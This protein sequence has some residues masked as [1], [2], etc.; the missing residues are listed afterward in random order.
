MQRFEV[1]HEGPAGVAGLKLSVGAAFRLKDGRS[2]VI[3]P[4]SIQ[5]GARGSLHVTCWRQV[6]KHSELQLSDCVAK[7]RDWH[8]WQGATQYE[9]LSTN[10]IEAT[11]WALPLELLSPSAVGKHGTDRYIVG[12]VQHIGNKAMLRPIKPATAEGMAHDCL[13]MMMHES[14]P[15]AV[16]R[17]RTAVRQGIQRA[18]SRIMAPRRVDYES[19]RNTIMLAVRPRELMALAATGTQS[20]VSAHYD[21][22]QLIF[23]FEHLEDVVGLAKGPMELPDQGKKVQWGYPAALKV[24][25]YPVEFAAITFNGFSVTSG[26]GTLWNSI[27]SQK[28]E[29]EV[30]DNLIHNPRGWRAVC[31]ACVACSRNARGSV[32]SV[33]LSNCICPPS[34]GP[35][36]AGQ[37]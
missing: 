7:G 2:G 20:L 10:D 37:P 21:Q 27:R 33:E 36:S 3:L 34:R 18:A 9:P 15:D 24:H 28:S 11:F 22:H 26:G 8:M 30:K 17:V 29:V 12:E 1:K 14:G 23:L 31:D 6:Y 4:G 19:C 13:V 16:R 25:L 35:G 32:I 5:E